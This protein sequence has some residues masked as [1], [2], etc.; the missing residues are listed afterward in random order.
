MA[1]LCNKHITE[2]L[3]IV[4]RMIELADSGAIDSEDNSCVALYGIIRDSAYRMRQMAEKERQQHIVRG[5][6]DIV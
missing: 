5:K 1:K 3:T 2:V 6:W 4:E